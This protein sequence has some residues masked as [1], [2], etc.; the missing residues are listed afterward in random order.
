ME[1][2]AVCGLEV[3][4]WIFC[5]EGCELKAVKEAANGMERSH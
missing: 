3:H 2:C 4:G 1:G 5:S